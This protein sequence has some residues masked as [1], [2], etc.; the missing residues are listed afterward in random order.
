MRFRIV[1]M[2]KPVIYK[3]PDIKDQGIEGAARLIHD[4]KLLDKASEAYLFARNKKDLLNLELGVPYL[5]SSD[6]LLQLK[7]ELAVRGITRKGTLKLWM[8]AA[9]PENVI[10]LEDYLTVGIDGVILNLDKLQELLG[11]YKTQDGG[12]YNRQVGAL[13]K[14]I[15]P[16]FKT[17]HKVK[18]PVLVKGELTLHPDILELVIEEGTFG[19]VVNTLAEASSIP[20]HLSWMERRIVSK[21]FN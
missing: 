15:K 20:D 11:G 14:F 19:V 16:L 3:L 6:E 9:V 4:K 12:Y 17:V 1:K 8:E 10:N 7:R 2:N 5:R 13:I 21:K 18:I